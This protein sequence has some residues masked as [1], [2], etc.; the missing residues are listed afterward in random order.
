M[1]EVLLFGATGHTGSLV[2][3]ALSHRG[4]D[5]GL[6]GRDEGKLRALAERLGAVEIHV[7]DASDPGPLTSALAGYRVL[8]SC[9]GPFSTYGAS[10]VRAAL[11]ARVHYLDSCGE[12]TFIRRL[13]DEFAARARSRGVALAPAM[14]FDEVPADLAAT[15]ATEGFSQAELTLTYSIP[16]TASPGTARSALEIITTAGAFIEEGETVAVTAGARRRWAPLPPPLGPRRTLSAPLAELELAPLH[17]SLS[18][19]ETYIAVEA[20][21]DLGIRFGLAPVAPVLGFRPVRAALGTALARILPRPKVGEAAAWWTLLAEARAGSQ[22]RNVTV[23]GR[24]LYGLSARLLAAGASAMTGADFSATGV[25]S[26]VQAVGA[27]FWHK[28][29]IDAGV[30]IEV[31]DGRWPPNNDG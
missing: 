25:V 21:E 13:K 11:D 26:P 9:V 5:F 2:A 10:A 20:W 8:L 17:L 1:P 14:A 15:L 19:L 23:V 22:W 3:H 4:V 27:D 18:R 6:A 29:L 31:Y 16:T 12:G 24:D 28:E 7:A 30:S